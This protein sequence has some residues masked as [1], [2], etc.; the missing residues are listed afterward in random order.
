MATFLLIMISWEGGKENYRKMPAGNLLSTQYYFV[1]CA[2]I[3]QNAIIWTNMD[4]LHYVLTYIRDTGGL[5]EQ[6]QDKPEL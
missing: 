1:K 4:F 6:R 5:L 3:Q 2:V